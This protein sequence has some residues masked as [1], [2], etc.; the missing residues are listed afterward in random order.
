M[1]MITAEIRQS[2]LDNG[3][4]LVREPD[5]DPR[6]VV[7]LFTPDAA[8]TWLIGWAEAD[9]KDLILWGLCDLGLGYPELGPVLLSELL[10]VRGH[11]NLRVERDISFCA[12]KTLSDYCAEAITSGAIQA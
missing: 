5:F 2:L 10:E 7:K 9:G 12:S 3:A 6:P 11:L 8:C 4:R 1:D